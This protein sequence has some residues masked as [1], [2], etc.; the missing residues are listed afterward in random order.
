M[1]EIILTGLRFYGYHGCLPQEREKGQDFVI[2]LKLRLSLSEAGKTDSLEKTV[3]YSKVAELT[4]K[5]V[6]GEPKNLL[7][8]V[9]EEIATKILKNFESVKEIKV[10]AHKPNAPLEA[11]FSDAAVTIERKK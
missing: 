8:A 5:I 11:D 6:E 9:A 3:D 7:E 2:D 4:R 1:D 10:T